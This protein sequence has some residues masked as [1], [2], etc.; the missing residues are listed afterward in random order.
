MKAM[1]L[2]I[3][4]GLLCLIVGAVGCDRTVVDPSS[5][6]YYSAITND[7]SEVYLT[8]DASDGLIS[9]VRVITPWNSPILTIDD[10]ELML[11]AGRRLDSA[12]GSITLIIYKDGKEWRRATADGERA[13]ASVSGNF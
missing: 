12:S 1:Q 11:I 2:V 5:D 8:Y 9:N 3:G 7:G 13:S 4:L 10:N 6:C